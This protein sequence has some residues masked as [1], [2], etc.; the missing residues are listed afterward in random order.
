[1]GHGASQFAAA[2]LA[3]FPGVFDRE[4]EMTR[5][6]AAFA[7]PAG[8]AQAAG[9][10]RADFVPDDL[11]LVLQANCGVTDSGRLAAYLLDAFAAR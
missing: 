5:G 3:A 9:R 8:R 11:P 6:V 2:A 4:R 1:M 10:L 7:E